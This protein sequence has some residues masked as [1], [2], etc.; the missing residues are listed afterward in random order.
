METL[1]AVAQARQVLEVR[2][3]TAQAR[4]FAGTAPSA[5][6][7]REKSQDKPHNRHRAYGIKP[8]NK[9]QTAQ[10]F[11]PNLHA[12]ALEGLARIA[13]YSRAVCTMLS[14]PPNML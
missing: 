7:R 13:P 14:P 11:P 1:F 10:K 4:R 2:D 8:Y 6:E 12:S 9:R 3:A 5:S